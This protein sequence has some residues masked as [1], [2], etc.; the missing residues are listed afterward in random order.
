[1]PP[2]RSRVWNFD[3]DCPASQPATRVTMKTRF[4]EL[5][6]VLCAMSA[7]VGLVAPKAVAQ[8][9]LGLSIEVNAGQ[10]QLSVT[11]ASDAVCQLQWT[12]TLSSTGHW[13]HLDHSAVGAAPLTDPNSAFESVRY[14]RAV[15]TPNIGMV[16]IP[17]GTFMLG[18]PTNEQDRSS[19]EGPQAAVTISRGFWMGKYE[20]TQGEYLAV[21]GENPSYF[22]GD[23]SG[24]PWYDQDYGIDLTLPVEQVTWMDAT[25]YCVLRTLQERAAGL[26]STNLVY[27]LPTEAE[28]EYACRA[29]TT[30]RFYYGDDLGYTN[31]ENYAWY[32]DAFG[33]T[34]PVGQLLPNAWG[35]Y[36]MGGNVW[37][38]C[39]DWYDRYS[40][41]ILTD[42]QGPVT[43]TARVW[44]GGSWYQIGRYCRSAYRF[45]HFPDYSYNG[46]GFRVVLAFAQ[47]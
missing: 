34:Q 15:W 7:T 22:N 42:P 33:A 43:G 8:T 14:Y 40:G 18:S 30:T 46:L 38:W 20:V 27:R 41:G 5:V 35:L 13:Y 1:M 29:G 25:N 17:P 4:L 24:P 26:I 11:G 6:P 31:L 37:E 9:P 10:A 16:W 44:R 28:W 47:P 19:I 12:D 2:L 36:D 3:L 39:Q 45:S 21:V 32:G 23:R